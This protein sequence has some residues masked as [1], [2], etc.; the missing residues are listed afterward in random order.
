M[1]KRALGT[2]VGCALRGPPP[3]NHRDK[4]QCNPG[5]R[6][7]AVPPGLALQGVGRPRLPQRLVGHV[8][9]RE[10]RGEVQEAAHVGPVRGGIRQ[11]LPSDRGAE[12]G[13]GES[14]NTTPIVMG[15]RR[16]LLTLTKYGCP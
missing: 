6:V 10:V 12:A 1:E 4:W 13:G 5:F 11:N 16:L 8:R 9:A 15:T 7:Q 2:V 14:P 3:E